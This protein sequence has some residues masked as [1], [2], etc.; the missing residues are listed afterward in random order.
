MPKLRS[1][2]DFCAHCRSELG[3]VTSMTLRMPRIDNDIAVLTRN[4]F[5]VLE[6]FSLTSMDRTGITEEFCEQLADDPLSNHITRLGLVGTSIGNKGLFAIFS[7]DNFAAL[8]ALDLH[9]G[10]LD[11]GAAK[12]IAAIHN[13]ANLRM[14]DLRYNRIDPAGLDMLKNGAVECICDNQHTRPKGRI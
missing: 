11:N 12:V 2:Q 9:D 14:I 5:H 13:L 1:Y 7:S 10:I 4:V 6:S 3:N 8:Q